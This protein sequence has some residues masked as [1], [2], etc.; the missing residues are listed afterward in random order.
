MIVILYIMDSLRPDFLSCYG[1][2]KQTSPHIDRLAKEGVIFTRAFAQATWT[3][4]SGASILS[5]T[6]PSVHGV[7][8]LYDTLPAY[9]LVA[10]EYLK[11][12][13]FRTIGVSSMGNISPHFGFGRGFDVFIELYKEKKVIER[14]RKVIIRNPQWEPHF[15]T[16]ESFV[17]IAT[18]EDVNEFIL[19]LLVQHGKEN[20]FVFIWSL[21]THM[22]Y[23]HR[24]VRLARFCPQD[25][26][27]LAE[28][29]EA[30]TSPSEI[31]LL[32]RLYEDMIFYND[33][34]LG[35]LIEKLKEVGLYDETF[36]I[37]TGDHGEAFGEH[38]V[39]SHG[40]IPHD[41]QIRIPLIMKFPFSE[42]YGKV[43]SIV[44]HIDIVPTLLD[45]LKIHAGNDG[46]I[47]GRSLLP[48]LRDQVPVNEYAFTE[49]WPGRQYVSHIAIRTEDYKF[50]AARRQE[51]TLR[52]WI[53]DRK[54]LWPSPWFVYKPLFLF[55][56]RS[57]PSEKENI[58]EERKDIARQSHSLLK[59]IVREN[60]RRGRELKRNRDDIENPIKE[61]E[62]KVDKEVA[63]QL[64]AL[65]Y[66]D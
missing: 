30:A 1:H 33:H 15:G 55:D 49:H 25:D 66:F 9:V 6:Y 14:R 29:I 48:L 62:A 50:I 5:S 38:G 19:P 23:F 57:D 27:K 34:H 64:K 16:G 12:Y 58:I 36:L 20:V 2:S 3:R 40:R 43:S 18:S 32:V 46:A 54:K 24:D 11:R 8:S 39:T 7:N 56:L 10:P 59:S 60:T 45:I 37:V 28:E 35:F 4:P 63:S 31:D 52:Q 44:Q 21:D 26:M 65:G 42:F 13:G 22:P 61:N 41:E 53:R 17:P 51:V 47:Q